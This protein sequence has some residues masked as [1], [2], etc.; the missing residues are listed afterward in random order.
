VK[1]EKKIMTKELKIK[2]KRREKLEEKIGN[3]KIKMK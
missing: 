2:E 1:E 3:G